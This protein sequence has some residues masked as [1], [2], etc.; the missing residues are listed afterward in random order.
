MPTRDNLSSLGSA[1]LLLFLLLLAGGGALLI[2]KT[3]PGIS[4]GASM[5]AVSM[6][7]S[8]L[9]VEL[10]LH[11]ILLSMLL[12]P[13]IVVGGVG[14]VS[15]GKPS[16]KGD[17]LVLR[18]E[19]LILSAVTLA[20]FART[21]LFKELGI[22]RKTPLNAAIF[23][24]IASLILAT[25][26][27]VFFGNVRPLRGFFFILKYLEYFFVFFITINQLR[28]PQQL[29]RLL[30]TAFITC[31]IASMIGISQIPSGDRV[32]A[33][34]EGQYGEPN[35][36]GGYLVFMLALILGLALTVNRLPV[37]IGWFAFG[38]LVSIPLLYTLS[39]SSWLAAVPML[40]TLILLSRRRLLLIIP[41]ALAVAFGPALLP[42]V[43]IKRYRY[44]LDEKYDRG[45]YRL[46][47][48]RFDTST[49]ARLETFEFGFKAWMQRPFFG[50][51]VTGF[52]FMDAQY[53]RILVEA[54]LIGLSAFLWL[55]WRIF[56][57]SWN[58]YQQA[59]GTPYEGL[60]LGYIAGAIA[61]MVHGVGANTFMIVR[62][63][64]P[65][66]YVTGIITVLP[67]IVAR[68]GTALPLSSQ[69]PSIQPTTLDPAMVRGQS[70]VVR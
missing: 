58:T 37:R 22:I 44:T 1:P 55:V 63:M 54:G 67:S 21:A 31:A 20:W 12:S 43:V 50:Y 23:A 33:P 52:T 25:L 51:G 39:R 28:E 19:D 45:D 64:E 40:L 13:E 36:F 38:G 24:Y 66:W 29:R 57:S 49:S 14:G 35:T 10:G 18:I 34:F 47:S 30:T 11:I 48:A 53:I 59:A 26:F 61:I 4:L 62:I 27:G 46:G 16:I 42:E 68:Q 60:S 5:L 65:F 70:S 3:G 17:L 7:V 2:T 56:R 9:N 8:F 32:A 15:I 41:L 69:T 6:L